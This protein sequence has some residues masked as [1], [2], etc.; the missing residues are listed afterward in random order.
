KSQNEEGAGSSRMSQDKSGDEKGT[1]TSKKSSSEKSPSDNKQSSEKMNR[2][3]D[4]AGNGGSTQRSAEGNPPTGKGKQVN[5]SGDKRSKVQTAFRDAVNV[6]H[7]T[8]VNIEISV[9]RRLPHDWDYV[10]VPDAVIAI[11]PQYR[12]YRFAYVGDEYV[13][14]D[15][16]TYEVVT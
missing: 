15:P 13:I 12:G 9:G 7:R 10:A 16:D 5:L 6:K 14:V 2:D 4:E 11:V 1:E 8:D 3:A